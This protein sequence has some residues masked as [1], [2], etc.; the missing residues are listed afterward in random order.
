MF[1]AMPDF[2][3]ERGGKYFYDTRVSL[4]QSSIG[5]V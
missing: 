1:P 5:Q 2:L 4:E 3:D